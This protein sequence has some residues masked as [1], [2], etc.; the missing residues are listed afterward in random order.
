MRKGSKPCRLRPVGSTA[1]CAS[2]RHR[3]P[4][5]RSGRP[6]RAGCRRSRC[7]APAG[8][9]S[10]SSARRQGARV[11]RTARA[12][13][14][15]LGRGAAT[16]ASMVARS[17][18]ASTSASH[19][20]SSRSTRSAGDWRL[21]HH[22]QAV[23]DQRVFQLQHLLGQVRHAGLRRGAPGGLGRGQFQR[24][25]LALQQ[26]GQVGPFG[27]ASGV[28]RRASAAAWPSGPAGRGTGRLRP[29][30]A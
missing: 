24:R 1:G 29:P 2:R 4:A 16:S 13:Q 21:A 10:A 3:V 11:V 25:G 26:H 27:A 15:L 14:R 17:R 30:A 19:M 18:P 22:V 5:A 12:V 6:A 9:R 8:V 23:R 7:P 28:E 20:A